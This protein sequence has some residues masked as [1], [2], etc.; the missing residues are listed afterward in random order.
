L[1]NDLAS[2]DAQLISESTRDNV[3]LT[4]GIPPYEMATSLLNAAHV[5][6]QFQP[7]K[8]YIFTDKLKAH[9]FHSL[10]VTLLKLCGNI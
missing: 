9:G 8:F 10:A 4:R 6:I 2:D 5:T 1:A 3:T 7:E